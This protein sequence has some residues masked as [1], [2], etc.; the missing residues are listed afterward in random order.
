MKDGFVKVAAITPAMRVADCEYNAEQIIECIKTAAGNGAVIAVLP[1]LS[2]TGYTCS[3]LFLQQAMLDKAEQC[4]RMIIEETEDLNI[5]SVFGVPVRYRSSLYNCAAVVC[6]GELL[7]LV[8][9]MNIPNYSEFYEARHFTA[10]SSEIIF[11]FAGFETAI[12]PRAI[13]I[14]ESMPQLRVGVEICEDLWTVSPPSEQ[15]AFAGANVILN[16]S[17]SDETIG[18]REYRQSLVKMQ[19]ARLISAYIYSDCGFG[20]STTDLVFSSHNIIAEN[21]T[22]LAESPRFCENITYADIDVFKLDSERRRSNTF[23]PTDDNIAEQ[24]YFDLDISDTR[25]ERKFDKNPFVP[26]NTD[27]VNSRCNE[28]LSIQATGLATRLKHTGIKNVVIGLSGGLDSTLA[29]IACVHAFDMLKLPRKNIIT[30]TM[31]CF[32]TTRRTKSN[33]E[34]LSE[35][36]G[37]TFYDIDITKSVSQHF[38]D[39]GH[40][41]KKLDVT[42]ENSQARERTQVLMDIANQNNAL[43]IGTGD[44]SELALG[45]ATYNGDHMSMYAINS[46][47]PKTLVRYI[48][49][50]EADNN[51]GVLSEVLYDIL[52]TPVSPELLPPKDGDISQ[53]TEELVGPYELHDFFLYYFVRFAFPP[54]KIYRIAKLAFKGIYDNDT[55]LSWLKVFVRR[56]F[57]QQ[58]KRS[59]L[60]DGP[61]VGSV[62]LSPRGDF[63]MPSDASVRLWLEEL[64]NLK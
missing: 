27:S 40:D 18:K 53:K 55:I 5:L 51:T 29:L 42:Y 59:C 11:N 63:R 62:T 32:G 34:K 13:F 23:P 22:V 3:D 50:Y 10:G 2:I 28:I 1:E 9:K 35:A 48:T 24:V 38:E 19:S 43:V 14:C 56:F 8:P 26:S 7:G 33:A 31:P 17:A 12:L 20:E 4:V 60:P 45:W 39:I 44:L 41:P 21:G 58:F 36:Y 47:I 25:L 52:N 64:E 6:K 16:L 49:K 57:T 61:K 46:S 30:V 37:V 54:S 15:L